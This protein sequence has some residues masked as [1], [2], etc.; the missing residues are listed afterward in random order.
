MKF[1][2][3]IDFQGITI[4]DG[5]GLNKQEAKKEAAKNSLKV[6]APNIY[7]ALYGEDPVPE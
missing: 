6:V 7:S 4:K 5:L 3:I 1:R 2:A